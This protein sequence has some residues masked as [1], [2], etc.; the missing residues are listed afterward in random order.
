MN[1]AAYQ[2]DVN[3]RRRGPYGG[4]LNGTHG[5]R[6]RDGD[7]EGGATPVRLKA[8]GPPLCCE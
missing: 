3:F 4:Y 2:M 8:P 5:R 1:P 6:V 7:A